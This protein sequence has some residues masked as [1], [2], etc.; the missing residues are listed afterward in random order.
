MTERGDPRAIFQPVYGCDPD[1]DAVQTE[2]L[3]VQREGGAEGGGLCVR[4]ASGGR[5]EFRYSGPGN[6]GES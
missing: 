3:F 4:L 1:T 2:L 6:T 5:Y